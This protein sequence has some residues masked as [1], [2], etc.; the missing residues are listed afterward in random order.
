MEKKCRKCGML[1]D[2]G[3]FY[4]HKKM[5]DGRL[6]ICKICTRKRVLGHR[7]ENIDRI[8]SYDRHRDDLPHRVKAREEYAKTPEGITAGN[9]AKNRWISKHPSEKAASQLV[10]NAVRDGRMKKEPCEVCGSVIR[11]HGHHDDYMKPLEVRWLCPKHH[12]EYHKEVRK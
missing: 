9:A 11:I 2:T 4:K 7:E 12:S 5:K 3:E 1:K 10:C 6:N 8:R